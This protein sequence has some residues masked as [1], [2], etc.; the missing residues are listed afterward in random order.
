MDRLGLSH[1]DFG[2]YLRTLITPGHQRRYRLD[3][4]ALS[5]GSHLRSLTT[6]MI[7]GTVNY[8]TTADVTRMLDLDFY[9][10]KGNLGFEPDDPSDAPLHRSRMLRVWDERYVDALGDWV[11]CP[12]FTGPCWDWQRDNGLVTVTA[13]GME[14]QAMGAAWETHHYPPKTRIDRIIRELLAAVG[15]VN[16]VVP[17]I[18]RTTP[19]K[20]TIHPLEPVWPHVEHLAASVDHYVFY[21]GMGRFHMRPFRQSAVY[22]FHDALLDRVVP[23]R[24]VDGFSNTFVVLG[25]NPKGPKKRIRAV[26]FVQ[27]SLSPASL[28]R[29]GVPLHLVASDTVSALD[30]RAPERTKKGAI[31]KGKKGHVKFHHVLDYLKTQKHAQEIADRLALEHGTTRTDLTFPSLPIPMLEEH[32]MVAVDD[33]AFGT[34]KLRMRQWSLPLEGGDAG[35]SQGSPM[36]VGSFLRRKARFR[37]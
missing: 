4:L 14:R 16:A 18:T 22:R 1:H 33:P 11:A 35:N 9:D 6:N 12:V 17:D 24:S 3:V 27:G 34:A 36:T 7:D 20:M 5:D 26:A 13:H 30:R 31:V 28:N 23:K 37:R 8:D 2:A 25:P 32:D 29:N 19:H 10:E 15:D 21:D